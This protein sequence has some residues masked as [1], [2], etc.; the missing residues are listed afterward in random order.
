MIVAASATALWSW[1]PLWS[2]ASDGAPLRIGLRVPRAVLAQ[3]LSLS[4]GGAMQWR[5]LPLG[6][7]ARERGGRTPSPRAE[8]WIEVAICAPRGRV[9]LRLGGDPA[10]PSGAGP[11]FVLRRDVRRATTGCV[12]V[13]RWEW[14]D[15]T[16][17]ERTRTTFAVGCEVGGERYAAGEARTQESAGLAQRSRWWRDRGRREAA[18]CGLLP[19]HRGRGAAGRSSTAARVRRRLG[20]V[21]DALVELPGDRGAGDFARHGGEVTNLEYDT[22][23]A[24]LRCAVATGHRRAFALAQRS[25]RHL[26]DRDLDGRSGLPFVHGAR[27]RTGVVE[28]GHA[29][30]QGLL[31]VGLLTADDG[32]LAAARALGR[33]LAAH[34][35]G[36]RGQHERLRSYGWPLLELEA[37]LR[38]VDDRVV[39]CAADR[40]AAAIGGRFD[41]RAGTW[42]FGEG[43][44]GRGVYFERAWLTAGLL[45]PALRAHLLRQANAPLREQLEQGCKRL[46]REVGRGARG[47]PTHYRVAAGRAFGHHFEL[48]TARSAWLLEAL[49]PRDQR[50]LL[51]RANLR[52]AVVDLV[53]LDAPDLATQ[54]TLLARCG[55]VWR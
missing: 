15:G 21:V 53:S 29:W 52:R 24:L 42:R 46:S 6:T 16:V 8:I 5:P 7:A 22:T 54:F 3:G 25:A 40:L 41:A 1:A 17:D 48:G 55:W 10:A 35:P 2:W 36:G 37:L 9:Q 4:G 12:S 18:R 49:P 44:E 11:A 51:G 14:C 31:W 23:F 13:T 32:A 33:A 20:V 50:R 47:L 28:S 39:A 38:V 30:L 34:L 19:L 43:E 45:V 26:R 27:H